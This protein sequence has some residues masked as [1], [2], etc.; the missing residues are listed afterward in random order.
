ME[1]NILS[2]AQVRLLIEEAIRKQSHNFFIILNRMK[3]R[4]EK[5]ERK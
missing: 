5:L 3:E 1:I 2:K 4:I